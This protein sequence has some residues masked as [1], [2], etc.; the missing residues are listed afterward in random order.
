MDHVAINVSLDIT[1]IP[2]VYLA[3][4]PSWVVCQRF[5]MLPVNVLVWQALLES[6]VLNVAPVTMHILNA[7]VSVTTRTSSIS[8]TKL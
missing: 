1:I 2:I 5:V 3:T 8:L 4:V 6:N 7:Y